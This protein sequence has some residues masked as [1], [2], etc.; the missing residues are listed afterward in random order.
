MRK[1]LHDILARMVR[2]KVDILFLSVNLR[3]LLLIIVIQQSDGQCNIRTR[4]LKLCDQQVI[5]AL[6]CKCRRREECRIEPVKLNLVFIFGNRLILHDLPAL[7]LKRVEKREER[8]R[9][10]QIEQRVRICDDTRIHRLI[11]D[12]VQESHPVNNENDQEDQDTLADI[13]QDMDDADT[14]RVNLGADGTY[15][16]RCDAVSEI[17]ADDNRVNCLERQYAC[18]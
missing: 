13:K 18:G 16:S 3:C 6:K 15:D 2:H 12:P 10:A 5:A 7:S 4:C 1:Q 8:Q 11:P 17:N 9:A 14:L